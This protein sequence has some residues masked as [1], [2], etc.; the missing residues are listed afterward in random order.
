MKRVICL[1]IAMA[2]AGCTAVAGGEEKTS[3][4]PEPMPVVEIRA[5]LYFEQHPPSAELADR[6]ERLSRA[7]EEWRAAQ[8]ADH[9]AREPNRDRSR[10]LRALA[11]ETLSRM[12]PAERAAMRRRGLRVLELAAQF[13]GGG[14]S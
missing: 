5:E 3:A 2:L 14:A 13:A 10:E 12:T 6:F 9:A 8:H 11:D 4:A 7:Q 1:G